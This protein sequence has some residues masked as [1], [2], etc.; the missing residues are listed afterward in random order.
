[1]LLVFILV[2]E[3]GK[4]LASLFPNKINTISSNFVLPY[5]D[6]TSSSKTQTLPYTISNSYYDRY[7]QGWLFAV[8]YQN[9]TEDVK[10][11]L[12]FNFKEGTTTKDIFSI[13]Y[14]IGNYDDWSNK[15]YMTVQIS[16]SSSDTFKMSEYCYG[17]FDAYS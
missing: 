16:T 2:I 4:E 13:T 10:Y 6:A 1:M 5:D 15:Y 9:D 14:K 11:G 17:M 8:V 3:D 7:K 12:F